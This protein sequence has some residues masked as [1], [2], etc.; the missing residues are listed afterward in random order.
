VVS[1]TCVGGCTGHIYSIDFPARYNDWEKTEPD[2]LF[3]AETEKTESNPK[4]R[5]PP[6]RIRG[7]AVITLDQSS[8]SPWGRHR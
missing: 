2:T 6:S 3:D 8:L 4:V 7:M 1:S 5:G